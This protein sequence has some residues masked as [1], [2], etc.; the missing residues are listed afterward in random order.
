MG[1]PFLAIF[2]VNDNN[3]FLID[4]S[5]KRYR[6]DIMSLKKVLIITALTLLTIA[7]RDDGLVKESTDL[8]KD[9]T[10]QAGEKILVNDVEFQFERVKQDSR[11]P[12][13][14]H[15][16]HQGRA[17][18]VVN[19]T[20]KNTPVQKVLSL[21][22]DATDTLVVENMIFKLGYLKPYPAI[23]QKIDPDGYTAHFIA[24]TR[25]DF[26]AATVVDVRTDEE[27]NTGHYSDAVHIPF[28]EIPSRASELEVDKDELVVVY[29]RSG[30]RAAKAKASL[31]KLG[32]TNVINAVDQSVT[33]N[34]MSNE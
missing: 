21:G 2:I 10:L 7:C 28:D 16:I 4:V 20:L 33:E 1:T 6:R 3:E 18:V 13:G 17:D 32:Y 8:P 24:F 34:L 26:K 22:P 30:N 25:G 5:A 11:C 9:F 19:Y 23:N 29:C 14:A 27:F 31:E 15:C 12:K